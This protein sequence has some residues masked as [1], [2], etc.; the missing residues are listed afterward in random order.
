MPKHH[1]CSMLASAFLS[2]SAFSPLAQATVVHFK[3]SMGDF[4]VNLFDSSTPQTVA[5]FLSYVNDEDNS[6][7]QSIIHRS[8]PGFVIQGGGIG[9]DAETQLLSTLPSEAPVENEPVFS[10]V[11]GTIAMAKSAS[12]PDSA[13]RQWFFSTANNAA[14]LDSQNGGFTAFGVVMGDGMD[15]VD[16]IAGLP[17]YNAGGVLAELPLRN[18]PDVD[19]DLTDQHYV[20][21]ESI[22]VTDPNTDTHL[23]LMPPL[24][25]Y[26]PPTPTDPDDGGSSSGGGGGGSLGFASLLGLALLG[27]RKRLR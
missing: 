4:D 6:F 8:S 26:E 11:R 22:T 2:L 19:T 7:D 16:A 10:N 3:T 12:S 9:Y 24:S 17:V 23:D 25:T 1:Y 20:I 15:V 18:D 27:F 21:I 13:T 14:N 5:N